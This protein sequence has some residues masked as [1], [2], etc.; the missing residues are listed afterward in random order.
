MLL[1]SKLQILLYF[2][3]LC[4]SCVDTI[5]IYS[6]SGYHWS[7]TPLFALGSQISASVDCRRFTTFDFPASTL[8]LMAQISNQL[9]Y[10]SLAIRNSDVSL[11]SEIFAFCCCWHQAIDSVRSRIICSSLQFSPDSFLLCARGPWLYLYFRWLWVLTSA[12]QLAAQP[13]SEFPWLVL[14]HSMRLPCFQ[15]SQ[16]ELWLHVSLYR[17]PSGRH[18]SNST[19]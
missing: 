11:W 2:D 6:D 5:Q 8:P 9:R 16:E 19:E 10:L 13:Y 1:A 14:D 17:Q 15:H 7:E 3:F 18:Y 12:M 4:P